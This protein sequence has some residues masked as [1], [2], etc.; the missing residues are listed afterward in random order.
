MKRN[1]IL[2]KLNEVLNPDATSVDFKQFDQ[3]VRDLKN[4]LKEK[5]QAKTL[6]DVNNQLEQFRKRIN[7]DALTNSVMESM[8]GF[9]K[10]TVD[11]LTGISTITEEDTQKLNSEIEILKSLLEEKTQGLAGSV[12]S[13]NKTSEEQNTKIQSQ[14][15]QV[16]EILKKV[17]TDRVLSSGELKNEI[18]KLQNYFNGKVSQITKDI[19][20]A[21]QKNDESATKKE[22]KRLED[23]LEQSRKELNNRISNLGGGSMNR[24][25]FVDGDDP[26]TKYTDINLIAGTGV[27]L[28]YDDNETTKK[29][30]ITISSD[31]ATGPEPLHF[32]EDYQY[33]LEDFEQFPARWSS[34]S[35]GS[36]A[37]V[38]GVM[39]LTTPAGNDVI[40]TR[41]LWSN[42]LTDF[43]TI[44]FDVNFNGYTLLTAGDTPRITFNQ[45]G[46]L[47]ILL[48]NFATN[49]LSTWQTISVPLT[50]FTANFDAT[51]STSGTG[52]ALVPSTTVSSLQVRIYENTAG[53]T[54]SVRNIVLHDSTRTI[55]QNYTNPDIANRDK[56]GNGIFRVQSIDIMKVTKDRMNNQLTE[57]QIDTLI[58]ALRAFNLTHIA[59]AC[60]YND[61]SDYASP[62]IA[63][64]PKKF[65]DAIHNAGL[66]VFWRQMPIQW[67]GDYSHAKDT[68]AGIGTAAGV[69]DGSETTTYL[70][71]IYNWI[72]QNAN[73]GFYK[74]GDFITP[75]PEPENGGITG[76]VSASG[77]DQFTTANQFRKW[78]RDA[79]TVVNA[80]LDTVDLK[81]KVF[82]GFFG[83]SGFIVFGNGG[84]P[85]GILDQRTADAMTIIGMDHYASPI[86][87][88]TTDLTTYE[89]IYGNFPLQIGEW[90]TI[91]E[92]TDATRVAAV[93]ETIADLTAK[94]YVVGLN[95]WTAV[96]GGVTNADE[97]ILDAV[98]YLPIQAGSVLAAAFVSGKPQG[99]A[100]HILTRQAPVLVSDSDAP[101]V[102]Q[103]LTATSTT[104][105]TWQTPSSVSGFT[106]TSSVISVS[107][108][109]AAASATDY[110]LFA[111]VGIKVTLP[112][113]ISN[114]NLYTVKNVS[115]SSVLVVTTAGQTIDDSAT[116]L[117]P[118]QNQTLSFNS[119]GSVWGVV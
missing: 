107:S 97:N 56:P 30:D 69:L 32:Q 44:S 53:R 42:I 87:D 95:Y 84:N 117:M 85:N 74:P 114:S 58:T 100:S 70:A 46:S 102:G 48:T 14:I 40:A 41:T 88:W 54:C 72:I 119:N 79:I 51:T 105:A 80:A 13:N 22:I 57:T 35:G 21:K 66:S 81:G 31:G 38:D 19:E 93:K 92:T 73:D 7:V 37:L 77:I 115:S 101:T 64:Y 94:T 106:R 39:T 89:G 52:T 4:S 45:A 61:P 104:K 27:T 99:V 118:I 86:T 59:V 5:I 16:N 75:L 62:P 55:Q 103:V 8:Q 33:V 11:A 116:A 71:L 47:G 60:P 24:Q 9:K 34:T 12:H 91:N 82:V 2:K 26:L 29:S 18:G 43:D 109:I 36:I 25:I 78:L 20:K 110:V 17:S 23:L 28:S 112:T 76:V 67:E 111:N 90:G 96:G 49:G 10:E 3:N 98:T 15:K 108:T 113:A 50:K 83:N 65:G 6:E 68:S 63:G 1:D